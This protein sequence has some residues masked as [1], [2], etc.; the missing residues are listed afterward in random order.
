MYP[1]IWFPN[2]I[3]LNGLFTPVKWAPPAMGR[4]SLPRQST[5]SL[6]CVVVMLGDVSVVAELLR[7]WLEAL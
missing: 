5:I 3:M 1:T 4:D 6:G 2:V 7:N